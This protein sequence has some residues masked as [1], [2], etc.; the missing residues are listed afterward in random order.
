MEKPSPVATGVD[1]PK[2]QMAYDALIFASVHTPDEIV[3]QMVET[4]HGDQG[5]LAEAVPLFNLFDP[6]RMAVQVHG[7]EYHL[8]AQAFYEGIGQWPP[9]GN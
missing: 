7:V 4:L 9:A 8:A 1:E 2:L 5:A 6:D 3:R